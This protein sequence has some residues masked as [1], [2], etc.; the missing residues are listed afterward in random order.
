MG[1]HQSLQ[2]RTGHV[3]FCFGFFFVVVVVVFKVEGLLSEKCSQL[4]KSRQAN[5]RFHQA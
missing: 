2:E 4:F 1:E 5:A 3:L